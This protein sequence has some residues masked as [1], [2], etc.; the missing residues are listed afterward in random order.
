MTNNINDDATVIAP[1]EERGMQRVITIIWGFSMLV[2]AGTL[3]AA[4]MI[5]AL[6]L[7]G[8]GDEEQVRFPLTTFLACLIIGFGFP[9][10]MTLVTKRFS[11]AK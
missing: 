9:G 8:L 2:G 1:N 11:T 10:V 4:V 3:F 5:A 6:H 7:G